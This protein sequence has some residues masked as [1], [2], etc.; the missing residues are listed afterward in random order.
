MQPGAMVQK[1]KHQANTMQEKSGN[2]ER[3]MR[4]W[5]FWLWL[6][7]LF[8]HFFLLF[9]FFATLYYIAIEKKGAPSLC[10][11]WPL[12]KKWL[13][14]SFTKE[15]SFGPLSQ[16]PET[17]KMG[18][19]IILFFLLPHSTRQRPMPLW[20]DSFHKNDS[21]LCQIP[22]STFDYTKNNRTVLLKMCHK[23]RVPLLS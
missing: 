15:L 13:V 23:K 11:T 7:S 17:M 3:R 18:E 6:V 1:D 21:F 16:Q 2:G 9:F 14:P 8:P 19:Q 4:F 22:L 10:Q 20:K 12:T 5:L